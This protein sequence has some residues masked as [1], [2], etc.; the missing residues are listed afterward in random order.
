MITAS[1]VVHRNAD[2]I[3]A[4]I[5]EELAMMDVD[6]GSYYLLDEVAAAIW[7]RLDRPT[8]VADLVADLESRYDVTRE[9][10][11]TDVLSLL[12]RLHDKGLLHVH[13]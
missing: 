2:A 5:G 10:C 11:E 12:H 3:T 6:A 7:S 4:P 13:G 1:A 9:Q 8:C